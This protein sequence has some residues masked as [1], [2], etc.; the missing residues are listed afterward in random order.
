MHGRIFNEEQTYRGTWVMYLILML[1]IP[2]LV[3]VSTLVLNSDADQKEGIIGLVFVL[4]IMIMVMTFIFNLK[5][6]T[7]IDSSGIHYRYFPLIKWR[8]IPREQIRS[9]D[10]ISFSP[11]TDH[12]GWGIKGNSTTKAYTVIGDKGLLLDVNENK[13]IVIGT[14]KSHE[15]SEFIENWMED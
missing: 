3:L 14:Q 4:F 6:T 5:L 1:E 2:T 8:K 9:A 13:K 12:G 7:R 15:L 11:L 10:V